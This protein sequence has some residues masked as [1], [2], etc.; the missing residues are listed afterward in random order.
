MNVW[1][2]PDKQE[3]FDEIYRYQKWCDEDEAERYPKFEVACRDA[4]A[5]KIEPAIWYYN[6]GERNEAARY[7]EEARALS[8]G[9]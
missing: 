5:V 7:Y 2:M 8:G 3:K 6:R 9:R 1:E 4:I